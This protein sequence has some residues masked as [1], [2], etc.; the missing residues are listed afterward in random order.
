MGPI[1]MNAYRLLNVVCQ[2]KEK[3]LDHRTL[4]D[5]SGLSEDNFNDAVEFLVEQHL[6]QDY[7]GVIELTNTGKRACHD[8]KNHSVITR[9]ERAIRL[10]NEQIN[11]LAT[12]LETATQSSNVK[13]GIQLLNR[14]DNSTEMLLSSDIHPN[15]ATKFDDALHIVVDVIDTL[16]RLTDAVE[17]RRAFLV[18]LR[19]ELANRPHVLAEQQSSAMQE[20]K[21]SDPTKVFVVHGR[22][23][24]ARDALFQFLRAIGLKPIEWAEA[25][26]ATG[27]PAPYIGE[28]LD[29]AFSMAQ[30][31][32]VLMTPDD[33]AYLRE[34]LQGQNE[35]THETRPTPQA[36]PNV[37]FEAGMALGRHPNRTI[38]VELGDLRPFSDVAGR[39]AVR[40]NNSTQ[41]RQDLAERLQL[42]N[43]PAE[44]SGVRDWHTAGNFDAA[45]EGL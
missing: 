15:E 9:T 5:Q 42:A 34:P 16:D 43:C 40:I 4:W 32:V 30:A 7:P 29:T 25:I 2:T 23:E 22:N 21:P 12:I 36:R 10:V 31:V 44:L 11:E 41:R 38:L 26:L 18:A 35:P 13:L 3:E 6:V 8:V 37:L 24:K 27:N 39:H 1:E 17:S 19:H 45:L 28:I 14:W 33:M 20:T